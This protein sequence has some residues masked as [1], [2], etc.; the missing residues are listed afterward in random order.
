[1]PMK[2]A[3][4]S[5]GHMF[6]ITSTET[7][8]GGTVVPTTD[9]THLYIAVD[10]EYGTGHI[11]IAMCI[12]RGGDG[13][14]PGDENVHWY[15]FDTD[16]V[17]AGDQIVFMDCYGRH[18]NGCQLYRYADTTSGQIRCL[19]I[20]SITQ[21]GLY[22]LVSNTLLIPELKWSTGVGN[23]DGVTVK[24]WETD[25]ALMPSLA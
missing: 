1:M 9:Q 12:M 18:C 7:V 23:I 17:N 20:M 4:P 5:G 25:S 22:N 10:G 19:L 8:N 6:T 11:Q 14:L 2:M 13:A 15:R 24:V 16:N 21:Y 3:T